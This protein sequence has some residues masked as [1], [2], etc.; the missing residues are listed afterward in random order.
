MTFVVSDTLPP[1]VPRIRREWSPIL[2]TRPTRPG[3]PRPAPTRCTQ[4]YRKSVLLPTTSRIQGRYSRWA[5]A[6]RRIQSS[7]DSESIEPRAEASFSRLLCLFG[8]SGKKATGY[9]TAGLVACGRSAASSAET[10]DRWRGSN[11][12]TPD[13]QFVIPAKAQSC[14]GKSCCFGAFAGLA[15]K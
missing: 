2:P 9:E 15:T 11:G 12:G 1:I 6:P 7:A 14:R 5:D 3:V 4:A 13:T 8:N 10:A